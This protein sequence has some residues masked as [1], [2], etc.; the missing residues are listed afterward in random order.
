MLRPFF[1][2]VFELY[3]AAH[4]AQASRFLWICKDQP[5]RDEATGDDKAERKRGADKP[6]EPCYAAVIGEGV[7]LITAVLLFAGTDDD[8]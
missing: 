5:Y 3:L 2:L 7:R 6:A 8:S 1:R 4:P